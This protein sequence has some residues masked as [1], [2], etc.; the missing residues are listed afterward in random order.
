[1]ALR[2]MISRR[3][4]PTR[5]FSDNGTNLVG[6]K[7]ELKK[8]LNDFDQDEML[9]QTAIH[10][11]EWHFVPP[12]SP[13]MGGCWERLIGSVKR[14][15]EATLKEQAP[16][17]EVLQTLLTEAK[18]SVNSRPLTYVSDHPADSESIT[19][20]HL[21]LPWRKHDQTSGAPGV[22]L[23]DDLT[24]RKQWRKSQVLADRFWQ[25]WVK[26][27]L[28]SLNRRTKWHRR[29]ENLEVGDVVV[30]WDNL[31]P[32]NQWVRGIISKVYP[33]QDERVRVADVRTTS[34]TYKRLARKLCVVVKRC[35]TSDLTEIQAGECRGRT[36]NNIVSPGDHL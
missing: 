13:H 25:R 29:A 21:L 22:F 27:Y 6:A 30:I 10:G 12:A 35:S 28:P 19:P 24:L 2:R 4:K 7:T 16:R 23:T 33:G 14:A 15:L 34:G 1:M 17:E 20:N 31:L 9:R 26:E 11:I 8:A 32:R 3:G 5:I 18:F 36:V